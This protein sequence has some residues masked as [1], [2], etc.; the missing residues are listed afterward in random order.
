MVPVI[1]ALEA[2]T[3]LRPWVVST[4][5]HPGLVDS[6]LALGGI[7][8]DV[9]LRVTTK[10]RSLNGLFA[11]ILAGLEEALIERFG[12]P[13]S[14]ITSGRKSTYPGVALVHGD[15]TS[16]AAAAL[17]AFH[18]RMPVAHVEAGL[19]THTTFSPFP[20]ELNRQLISRIASFHLAPTSVAEENLIRE[21]IA[22]RE[23][24]VTGNTAIDAILWSAELHAP[25]EAEVLSDLDDDP[26]AV[27]VITAHR[28]ENWGEGVERIGAAIAE[29]ATLR[30]DVRFVLAL[31][32]NPAVAV[33]LR[34]ALEGYPNVDL[35]PPMGYA[36]FSRLLRRARFAISDSG[37]IQEEAPAVGT[38]VLV[39]RETTERGE[40]VSAGTVRLVGTD[41]ATIVRNA[42]ELIDDEAAYLEMVHSQNPFG[43]GH[44]AD[45][46]VKSIEH[47]AFG[48]AKPARFGSGYSRE[49]VL[50]A[51]GLSEG[52]LEAAR[53]MPGRGA[54]PPEPLLPPESVATPIVHLGS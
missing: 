49:V 18:L 51:A 8:P 46:I 4:G 37:G 15:T 35:V 2:S 31:H 3:L 27:V 34:D 12:P 44:A 26:R 36:S 21:G 19:R 47:L 29:L 13:D 17:S 42:L 23:I 41:P 11:G 22:Y 43:D 50:R 5:Q 48:T 38:P 14:V 28:R 32:P 45:R 1:R 16:A 25:Y 30:P 54:I 33:P 7:R 40:A 53:A 6:V 10:S 52:L 24:F 20:E 39:T 9:D